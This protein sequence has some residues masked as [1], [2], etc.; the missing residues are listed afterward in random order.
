MKIAVAAMGKTSPATSATVKTS[1]SSTP[2]TAGSQ[3]EFCAQPGAPSRLPAQFPGGQRRWGG[4]C[5]QRGRRRGGHLWG[6]G[7]KV[8][9][10]VQG[11][12]QGGGGGLPPGRA[13]LQRL[14]LPQ[15]RARRRVR[16]AS[17]IKQ[18]PR[19]DRRAAGTE[20]RHLLFPGRASEAPPDSR[21]VKTHRGGWKLFG[22]RVFSCFCSG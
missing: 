4:H 7:V 10:G 1:S 12:A 6:A 21:P 2:P 5:R 13:G 19:D 20:A 17:V 18:A 15:A 9:L 11:D 8:I 22:K 3:G 14:C 16:R